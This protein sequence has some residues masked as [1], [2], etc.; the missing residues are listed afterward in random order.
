MMITISIAMI[1][2]CILS[3]NVKLSTNMACHWEDYANYPK[4]LLDLVKE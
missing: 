2:M 1:L 4:D 3:K